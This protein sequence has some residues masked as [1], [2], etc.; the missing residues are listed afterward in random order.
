MYKQKQVEEMKKVIDNVQT[1]GTRWY[2]DKYE[3]FDCRIENDDIA[4]ELYNAGYRKI[5]ED[6]VVIKKEAYERLC[7]LAYF[8]NGEQ[9][10]RKETAEKFAESFKQRMKDKYQG[11]GIWWTEIVLM[12]IKICKEITEGGG[13]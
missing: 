8:G 6:E 9:T 7:D 11:S 5:P 10:I 12:A 13:Q 3:P 2:P 4:Y 1:Y